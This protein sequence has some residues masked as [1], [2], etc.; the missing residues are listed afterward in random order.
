[1]PLS[2]QVEGAGLSAPMQALQELRTKQNADAAAADA[3]LHG[4]LP[5]QHTH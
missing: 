4:S 2:S 3:D 1:M 5:G